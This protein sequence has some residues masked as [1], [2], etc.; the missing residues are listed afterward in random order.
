MK[1]FLFRKA[2]LSDVPILVEIYMKELLKDFSWDITMQKMFQERYKESIPRLMKK[3]TLVVYLAYQQETLVGMAEIYIWGKEIAEEEATLSSI[4]VLP[5]LRE[6]DM[7]K[8]LFFMLL[9]EAK[10]R[11]CTVIKALVNEN[12]EQL[13]QLGFQDTYDEEGNGLSNEM[14]LK[15]SLKNFKNML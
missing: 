12:R 9:Q 15:I 13:Y 5:E 6:N 8:R 10:K 2:Q 14:E 1:D 3:E 7:I 4:Y 11:N